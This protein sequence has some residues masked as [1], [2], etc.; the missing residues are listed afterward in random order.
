MCV[1]V[2]VC[3]GRGVSNAVISNP[4]L[5]MDMDVCSCNGTAHKQLGHLV[6]TRATSS[7]IGDVL[8]RT[9][10]D[11]VG[12]AYYMITAYQSVP[13]YVCTAMQVLMWP[14]HATDQEGNLQCLNVGGLRSLLQQ[15]VWDLGRTN[16]H[17][18]RLFSAY[19]SFLL[20]KSLNQHSALVSLSSGW[21][22]SHCTARK[23][24]SVFATVSTR[25]SKYVLGILIVHLTRQ[26]H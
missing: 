15:S 12:P 11:N 8:A 4:N 22:K 24:F 25:E 7:W 26:K 23:A 14:D 19:F 21:Q 2:C 9:S 17:R 1:C 6:A 18:N 13:L 3:G 10:D 16:W 20:R 5:A